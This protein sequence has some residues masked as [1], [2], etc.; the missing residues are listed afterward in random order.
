MEKP[1]TARGGRD[2]SVL[3]AGSLGG[4]VL[5]YVFFAMVTRA[6]GADDAAPVAVLWAWWSFAGA[7]LTFPIQHWIARQSALDHGEGGIRHGLPRVAAAVAAVSLA[8]GGL[9]WLARDRL[10]GLDGASFPLLVVAVGVGSA[11][12][13][14]VRGTLSARR[15]FSAVGTGLAVENALRCAAA[16][17]LMAGG[18]EDPVA[19]GLALVAGYA[20]VLIW[21]AALVPRRGN[22]G[23]AGPSLA[24]VSAASAGQLLAQVTLT[25]GPV[26]LAAVGGA[27]AE[28]TALFAGLALFRAPYTLGLGLVSAL[29]GRLTRLVVARRRATLRRVRHGVVAATVVLG[30]LGGLGA[31]WLGP[32]LMELVFGEGVR[33]EPGA[34]AVIA[35]G[36]VFALANLVWTIGTLARG[37]PVAAAWVWLV[38]A[39][40]GP[41]AFL[42]RGGSALDD[43]AATFLAVEATA[44][45]AFVVL[46]VRSDRLLGGQEDR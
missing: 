25:G 20:A 14:L 37:R 43:T 10:F 6:L 19:Y 7:A 11:L 5:A 4:G 17:V 28:V 27:P 18:V 29:T 32:D 23:A 21:P 30:L 1:V 34:T 8:A 12:I 42:L 45:V 44:W 38:A 22:A 26:L 35:V 15:R 9:A 3:A 13:G 31:A 16:A 36:S 39:P 46:D 24:F 40:A 41:A 2:A 33:L